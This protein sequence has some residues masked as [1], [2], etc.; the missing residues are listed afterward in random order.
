MRLSTVEIPGARITP[1]TVIT[2]PNVGNPPAERWFRLEDI[3]NV[4]ETPLGV[5]FT[6]H[7]SV[8]RQRYIN[9]AK[10]PVKSKMD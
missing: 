3:S 7:A 6:A 8:F 1:Q 5:V 4:R 9:P 2:P 10:Y